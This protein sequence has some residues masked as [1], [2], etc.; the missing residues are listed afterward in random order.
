MSRDGEER[1]E[2]L[3]STHDIAATLMKLSSGYLDKVKA[4]VAIPACLGRSTSGSLGCRATS[5]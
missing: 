1:C 3:S 2:T 5:S 4:V